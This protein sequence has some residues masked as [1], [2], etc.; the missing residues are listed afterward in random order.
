MTRA[1]MGSMPVG[2]ES[3]LHRIP[4]FPSPDWSRPRPKL[5]DEAAVWRTLVEAGLAMDFGNSFLVIAG[6][7]DANLERL[8]PAGRLASFYSYDRRSELTA[9][10]TVEQTAGEIRFVRHGIRDTTTVNGLRLVETQS[11]YETGRDLLDVIAEGGLAVAAD[12]LTR[13]R[14]I[15][16]ETA[17]TDSGTAID[18]VPHNLIVDEHGEL[19]VID[20]EL[21]DADMPVEAVVRRGVYWFANSVTR[22]SPPQRWQPHTTVGEVMTALG[23]FAGLPADGSW[24]EL[25]IAEEA[26]LATRVRSG[27]PAGTDLAAWREHL[28]KHLRA[29]TTLR[30]VDLNFGDR[31]P[32]HMQKTT[33]RLKERDAE[34]KRVKGE[35][36]KAKAALAATPK[37]RAKRVVGRALP[38]GTRRRRVAERI[39]KR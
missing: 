3:L 10:T 12:Y 26:Q 33:A 22:R 6:K 7:G 5:S 1:V 17:R 23:A 38:R 11:H 25:A 2:C 37:A 31:L 36:A 13:W 27:P 34:L 14:R 20:I 9:E 30:L 21:Y 29:T 28:E 35:L 8:W 19:K 16:D 32:E 4:R 15:I 18:L 39:R 24:L